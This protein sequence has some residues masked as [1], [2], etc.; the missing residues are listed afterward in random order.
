MAKMPQEVMDLLNDLMAPK[1]LATCAGDGVLNVAPKG[2]LSA[3]DDETVVFADLFGNKTNQNLEA[4]KQVALVVFK[5]EVP[6]VGYQVKGSFEGFQREGE[7]FDAVSA[8]VKEALNLDT[9]AVG[10][11]KVNEV[12]SSGVPEPGAKLA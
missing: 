1:V 9:K 10:V 7:L 12:Y 6:P 3:V 4:N 2:T 11:I 5:V 8:K